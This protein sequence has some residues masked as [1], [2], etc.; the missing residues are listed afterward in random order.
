[1]MC[2]SASAQGG[3]AVRADTQLCYACRDGYYYN[4]SEPVDGKRC[5]PCPAGFYCPSKDVAYEC[6]GLS[7]FKQ[8]SSYVTVQTSPPGSVR[9][10]DCSC[11]L[12]VGG[13]QPSSA[14]KGLFGCEPC[15]DGYY[16][17]KG[18]ERCEACPLGTYASRTQGL[19]NYRQCPSPDSPRY[20]LPGQAAMQYE[21]AQEPM[22]AGAVSCTLCP[23]DR[24]F[25]RAVG[26]KSVDDCN[27]CPSGQFYSEALRSCKACR[28]VCETPNQYETVACTDETD[29]ECGACDYY[30]CSFLGEYVDYEAGCPGAIDAHRP[31]AACTNKPPNSVYV[32][33]SEMAIISGEECTWQ[34]DGGYYLPPGGGQE[35][36]PCTPISELQC[37]PGFV[38][39]PCSPAMGLDASCTQACDAQAEGK[40]SDSTSEWEWTMFG[41][42]GL[43]IVVNPAGGTDG[44]PNV[45]CLWKCR[46]GFTLRTVDVGI[47]GG[48]IHLCA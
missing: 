39:A 7:I 23:A 22:A 32:F 38:L 2:P 30:S 20:I 45:G 37:R 5:V 33:P 47:G 25:T 18:A 3:F 34:C 10:S 6:E 29:R 13:F 17:P 35:C 42:D 14:S 41:E 43:T 4:A 28:A 16:A 48:K 1:M 44:R 21:C 27:R 19:T 26:S 12:E 46:D 15:Q 9:V 40:P 24:P 11:T 31:C 36:V 8:G